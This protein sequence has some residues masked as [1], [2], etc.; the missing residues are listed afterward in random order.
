MGWAQHSGV[1]KEPGAVRLTDAAIEMKA[2]GRR[3]QPISATNEEHTD[4]Q[5]DHVQ[6]LRSTPYASRAPTP[7]ETTRT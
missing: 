7:S 2:P 4:E 3:I 5:G 1:E 6:R